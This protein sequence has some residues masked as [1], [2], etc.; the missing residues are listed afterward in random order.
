TTCTESFIHSVAGYPKDVAYPQAGLSFDSAGNLYGT[1]QYGG[2]HNEGSVFQMKQANGKWTYKMI[3]TFAGGN[4]GYYP[5]G[6]ITQGLHGYYYCTT[7]Y[8]GKTYNS[9]TVYR[10]FQARGKW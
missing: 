9:G 6:G 3:H 10:L 4:G 2:G 5:V 7:Y 1:T 8:G